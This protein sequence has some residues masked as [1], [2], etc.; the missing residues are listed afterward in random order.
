MEEGTREEEKD[1]PE[2]EKIDKRR[3]WDI[4]DINRVAKHRKEWKS[5]VG[6]R[7]EHLERWERQRGHHYEL[8]GG[9]EGVENRCSRAAEGNPI[10][11]KL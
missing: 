5:M 3:G 7:M 9:E 11:C 4:M 8:E 2:L 10:Q 6:K 1:C